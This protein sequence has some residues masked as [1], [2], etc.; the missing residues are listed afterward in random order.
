M[1]NV[2]VCVC[3]TEHV[4]PSCTLGV[5]RLVAAST[6][7]CKHKH[8]HRLGTTSNGDGPPPTFVKVSV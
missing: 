2:F 5:G 6:D 1:C 8:A 7:R 4:Y 3:Q